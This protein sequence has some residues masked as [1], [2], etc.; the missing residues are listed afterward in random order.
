MVLLE[1]CNMVSAWALEQML[2]AQSH[3]LQQFVGM[4]VRNFGMNQADNFAHSQ[5]N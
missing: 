1:V 3:Q 2:L 4:Q 5:M